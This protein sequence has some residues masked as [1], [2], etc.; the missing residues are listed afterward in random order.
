MVHKIFLDNFHGE[1]KPI[2]VVEIFAQQIVEK[3]KKK[4]LYTI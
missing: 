3:P 2:N 1:D 4:V